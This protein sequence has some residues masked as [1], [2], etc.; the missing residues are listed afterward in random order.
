[1]IDMTMYWWPHASDFHQLL[2]W[3]SR[4]KGSNNNAFFFEVHTGQ[5]EGIKTDMQILLNN[6][7]NPARARTT[8]MHA[9]SLVELITRH[10]RPSRNIRNGV[11]Q[12]PNVLLLINT[13]GT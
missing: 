13:D 2:I 11:L 6:Y 4:S 5:R 9:Q 7:Y 3:M 1:M 8:D 10:A 12:S